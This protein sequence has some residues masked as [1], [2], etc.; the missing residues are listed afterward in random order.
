MLKLQKKPRLENQ[1]RFAYEKITA[2][3]P[4]WKRWP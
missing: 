1:G 4:T 3:Q 2:P